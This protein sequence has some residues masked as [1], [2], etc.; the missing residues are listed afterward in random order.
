MRKGVDLNKDS[1]V[2]QMWEEVKWAMVK[3]TREVCGSVKVAERTQRM[4]SEI[5]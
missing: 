4:C 2:E 5:K 3:G 1:D